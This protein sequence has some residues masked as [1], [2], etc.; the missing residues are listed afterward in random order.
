MDI[1]T[2]I[3]LQ[4]H[5]RAHKETA[6]RILSCIEARKKSGRARQR[7]NSDRLTS[8]LDETCQVLE[9]HEKAIATVRQQLDNLLSLVGPC[10]NENISIN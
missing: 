6:E 1:S 7:Q 3:E 5:L 4:E 2:T 9:Y 8:R 10:N